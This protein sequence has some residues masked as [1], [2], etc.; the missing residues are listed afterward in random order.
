MKEF[1]QQY[2]YLHIEIQEKQFYY[3]HA[4]ITSISP[5]HIFF[6]DDYGNPCCYKKED[7]VEIKLSNK[8]R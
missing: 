8:G 5:T 4:F 2:V 6:N 7:I 1:L 3:T